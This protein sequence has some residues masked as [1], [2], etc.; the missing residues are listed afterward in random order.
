MEKEIRTQT[1]N[2]NKSV[3]PPKTAT[4]LYG[5]KKIALLGKIMKI[6]A[7]KEQYKDKWLAVK[8]S[9][10]SKEH[11]PEEGELIAQADNREE[12][13]KQVPRNTKDTI[14]IFFSGDLNDRYYALAC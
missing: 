2:T 12:L 11:I 6:T 14:Y 5:P 8:V 13:W 7:I 1:D 3:C 9:K 10:M 4:G